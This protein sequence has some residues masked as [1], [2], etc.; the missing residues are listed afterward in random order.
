LI[1]FFETRDS[2]SGRRIVDLL[3]R[4]F[5]REGSPT[6]CWGTR[7]FSV[8]FHPRSFPSRPPSAHRLEQLAERL[9][10]QVARKEIE[11]DAVRRRGFVEDRRLKFNW[12]RWNARDLVP[13]HLR[14]L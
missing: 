6:H 4:D 14:S 8:G 3:D 10:I 11:H 13:P 5:C 12:S 2:H 7:C 1:L 9:R